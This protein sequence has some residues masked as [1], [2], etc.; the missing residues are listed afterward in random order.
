MSDDVIFE[1]RKFRV[2]RRSIKTR[3]GG[4]RDT[5]LIRHPGAV[6]I[7]PVLTDGSIVMIRNF[8]HTLGRELWELPAG[9]LDQAG[10]L[11]DAAALRELEEEAGYRADKIRLLCELHPSPGVMD[12]RILAYVATGLAK[13]AQ[14]LEPGE[15]IDVELVPFERAMAM[16]T[17][18]TITDAKTLVALFRWE[19][20]RR[21]D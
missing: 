11:P 13:T 15:H 2:V 4:I 9:T 5:H 21:K 17:D 10:E 16:A 3:D 18:G 8:R 14:R 7:L 19:H 1:T 6:V 20:E 12:E